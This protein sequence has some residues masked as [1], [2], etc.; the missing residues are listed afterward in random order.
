[1]MQDAGR[2]GA[3]TPYPREGFGALQQHELL[4]THSLARTWNPLGLDMSNAA[5]WL[6]AR[7][8]FPSSVAARAVS[9]RLGGIP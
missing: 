4:P 1:M 5:R 2:Y 7:A 3:C 8:V 9:V 6:D